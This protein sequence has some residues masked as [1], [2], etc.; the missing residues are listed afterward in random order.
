MTF[1]NVVLE[2]WYAQPIHCPFCGSAREP[3]DDMACKHLLYVILA[4]DF[5]FSAERFD[6]AL[7]KRHGLTAD[8][9]A[10]SVADT[11]KIGDSNE[12]AKQIRKAEFQSS[13]EFQIVDPSDICFICFA[14]LQEELCQF[15]KEHQSPYMNSGSE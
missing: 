14:P 6:Q 7:D 15:G 3:Q 13:V 12:V 1:N 8:C 2:N 10:L 4:G 9:S 5:I 11:T